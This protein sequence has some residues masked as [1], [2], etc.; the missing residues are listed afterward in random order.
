MFSEQFFDLLL[1]FG[2]DWKV[3]SVKI[4]FKLSEVD[5][6]VSYLGN[7]I[8]WNHAVSMTIDPPVDG[9]I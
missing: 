7:Q 1:N 3:D 2:D 8:L 9:V 6:F 4:D 5:V